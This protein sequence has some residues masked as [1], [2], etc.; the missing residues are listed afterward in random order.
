MSITIPRSFYEDDT[1]T[2]ARDLLGQVLCRQ[3]DD[4]V[5]AGI[6]VETEA[7]CGK[8]DPAAHSYKG[9][10][11]RCRAMFGDSGCAYIF[12]IYGMYSCFNVTSGG[13]DDPDAVLIRAL[14]PTAGLDIM[15]TRRSCAK[16]RSVNLKSGRRLKLKDTE[17]CNGPGKICTA[18]DITS[19]AYG[20]DLTN[21]KSGLWIEYGDTLSAE[22]I[23]SS[24]RINIDYADESKDWLWR[25]TVKGSKYISK[26]AKIE[27]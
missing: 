7:Y 12:M 27:N 23:V 13:A 24:K 8:T 14:E 25:F 9:K 4:G 10:T 20:A 3:T 1:I 22:N 18:M 6:I 19:A 16:K 11:E 17:L 15:R 5:T 26:S 2:V 21:T